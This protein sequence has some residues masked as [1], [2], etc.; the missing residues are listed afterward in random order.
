MSIHERVHL[1]AAGAAES[2]EFL[3]AHCRLDAPGITV[4]ESPRLA[5]MNATTQLTKELRQAY[6]EKL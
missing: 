4:G 1:V 2:G 5:V 3:T 6:L